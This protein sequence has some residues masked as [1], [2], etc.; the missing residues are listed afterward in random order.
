MK[1]EYEGF[2]EHDDLIGA[3]ETGVGEGIT[4][5]WSDVKPRRLI[6]NLKCHRKKLSD[7]V[8]ACSVRASNLN[9]PS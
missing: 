8:G 5:E 7:D 4:K 1:E 3:E 9:I 6:K 2:D